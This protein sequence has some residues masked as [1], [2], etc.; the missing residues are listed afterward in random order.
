MGCEKFLTE[1][2]LIDG[3]CPLHSNKEPVYQ[4]EENYFLKLG[5]LSK[6]I[7]EKIK[8][9]EYE[10]KPE[11]RK[12]EILSRL[13]LGVEDVSI[14]REGVSWGIPL[15]WDKKQTA[16]V[17]VDALINYYSATQFVA[18]KKK[19]WPI[20]LHLIGKD[21]LWFHTVIWQALLFAAGLKELPKTIFA[22]GFFTINGQKM[23]KSLGNV[24]TPKQLVERYGVDGTRYLIIS[25]YSFG[26]DGDISLERFDKKYN[27]D[28]ANGLG[29]LVARTVGLAGDLKLKTKNRK[30]SPKV[31]KHVENYQFDKALSEIWQEI[32]RADVLI[33][34]N[35][36]WALKESQKEKIIKELK[37]I[38]SQVTI[39]LK[40]FLPATTQKIENYSG[41]ALF[42]RLK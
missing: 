22:H 10:I 16:Y 23:S 25:A 42:P 36:A 26:E 34:E 28:L 33:N 17:W 12:H 30:I 14:S 24:F 39:D 1:T 21:I 40:P 3:K 15:P 19:F 11:K 8:K 38:I 2:D 41:K 13:E 37:E 35:K 20:G 6:I 27:A 7:L 31:A 32:K 5:N 4:E 18:G 9:G 29:N